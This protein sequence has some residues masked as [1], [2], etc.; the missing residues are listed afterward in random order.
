[1]GMGIND[2][3]WYWNGKKW[4]TVCMEMGM[5]LIPMEINS[6]WRMPCLAYVIARKNTVFCQ[7]P[8]SF[9]I[10]LL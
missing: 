3:I 8:I 7:S 6:H 1:M 2:K 10:I 4:E 9:S 5:A